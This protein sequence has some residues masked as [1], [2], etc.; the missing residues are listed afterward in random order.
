MLV[1]RTEHPVKVIRACLKALK[2]TSSE[3]G[4]IGFFH[5][6]VRHLHEEQRRATAETYGVA[7]AE[8]W[9]PCVGCSNVKAH[10]I[11][12]PKKTE[13]RADT[14]VGTV[15][16]DDSGSMGVPAFGGN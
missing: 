5:G 8:N 12:V 16:M 15:V 13:N 1:Q 2:A 14:E 4:D 6:I 9:V 3:Y 10:R 11:A 7:L